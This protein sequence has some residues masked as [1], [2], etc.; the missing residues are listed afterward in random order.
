M[1]TYQKH[2]NNPERLK[3]FTGL[4]VEQFGL[5]RQRL[6]PVWEEAEKERLV[7]EDRK[8][9]IGGGRKYHLVTM[10]DKLLVLVM[11]YK[12]YVVYDMLALLFGFDSSN[13]SRL[14]TKLTP[15]FEQ[16]ADPLL[17]G[18]VKNIQKGRK[19]IKNWDEFAKAFP[20][21]MEIIIDATEQKRKRPTNKK[22]QKNVYSGKKHMHSFKTQITIN[23]A[24]RIINVSKS[25]P[26]RIHDKTILLNEETLD[27][28]PGEIKK[29][30]DRGYQKIKTD[31][32]NHTII[33][34]HKKNRWKNELT[35]SQ[36]IYNTKASKVRIKIEHAF[37]RMKK[38][39]I[40]SQTYRSKEDQYNQHFR[41]IA[42]LC[43]FRL[44]HQTT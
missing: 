16:A 6:Q 41:N 37:S 25:Y 2:F 14:I 11:F 35:R 38:Y 36:K 15:L 5:L 27:K 44:I 42:A 40:L 1:I 17:V 12:T 13:I 10:E 22:K 7:R 39:S 20:E 34:P 8:R 3:R 31:Y 26:G 23:R 32:P 21:M 19:K 9:G 28:L 4:T 33:L 29:Y 30:L 43:N 18:A 24:G